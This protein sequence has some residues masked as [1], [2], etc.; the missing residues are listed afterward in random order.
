MLLPSLVRSSGWK[1]D[2]FPFEVACWIV[3]PEANTW[4][5][6]PPDVDLDELVMVVVLWWELPQPV[7]ASA[8]IVAATATP[9]T[10]VRVRRGGVNCDGVIV[11]RSVSAKSP[12]WIV[13]GSASAP[14]SLVTA[15]LLA[16]GS[17]FGTQ[18]PRVVAC[19]LGI[20]TPSIRYQVSVGGDRIA[21]R[22]AA[23]EQP[24][25]AG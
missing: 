12:C 13:S 21:R 15:G 18:L 14:T 6:Y 1:T 19:V 7:S 17:R 16:A 10:D 25:T 8:A 3:A 9:A 23:C 22:A 5:V 4:V 20:P 11:G 2:A 24:V